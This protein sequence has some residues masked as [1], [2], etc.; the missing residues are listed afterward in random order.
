MTPLF[1]G[2]DVWLEEQD[3]PM[4]RAE[5][6]EERPLTTAEMN[7]AKMTRDKADYGD[8]LVDG[9]GDG[10]RDPHGTDTG[11]RSICLSAALFGPT[12]GLAMGLSG[13]AASPNMGFY[14]S[15]PVAF[16]MTVF[17]VRLGQ[18]LGNPRHPTTWRQATPAVGL[19]AW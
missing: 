8:G 4:T 5:R 2:Y 7:N 3:S 9:C 18:W 11:D 17:N 19:S 16:L 15:A 10:C 6:R 14:T 12:L 13:A 1:C